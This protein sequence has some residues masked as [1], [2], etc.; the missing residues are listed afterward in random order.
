[1]YQ[2]PLVAKV[3]D[4]TE[5]LRRAERLRNKAGQGLQ[6]EEIAD[7]CHLILTSPESESVL[8]LI[9]RIATAALARLQ[10]PASEHKR[11]L[12]ELG[13]LLTFPQ[14]EQTAGVIS[15]VSDLLGEVYLM[16]KD[17]PSAL[18]C[19]NR[20]VS[21]A[22]VA[23][24]EVPDQASAYLHLAQAYSQMRNHKQAMRYAS[25]AVSY[26]EAQLHKAG[27]SASLHHRLELLYNLLADSEDAAGKPDRARFWRQ[28]LIR[29]QT[30]LRRK[31]SVDGFEHCLKLV[32]TG[33]DFQASTDISSSESTGKDTPTFRRASL[34]VEVQGTG[35]PASFRRASLQTE[36][37]KPVKRRESRACGLPQSLSSLVLCQ[38]YKRLSH[39][40]GWS[41]VTLTSNPDGSWLISLKTDT[42]VIEK[43]VD[44]GHPWQSFGPQPLV[45]ML[46]LDEEDRVVLDFSPEEAENSPKEEEN[47]LFRE[48]KT[49]EM[50][51]F[52]LIYST[53]SALDRVQIEAKVGNTV[54]RKAVLNDI[55]LPTLS[56]LKQYAREVLAPI[57]VL[58]DGK[59]DL[60]TELLSAE[61]EENREEM[62]VSITVTPATEEKGPKEYKR[63]YESARK[64]PDL[65]AA[66]KIQAGIRGFLAR[67]LLKVL[68]NQKNRILYRSFTTI[69]SCIHEITLF[70]TPFGQLFAISRNL[71]TLSTLKCT[72]P[73]PIP[74]TS[75]LLLPY[76]S[77][78][79]SPKQ[80]LI[81]RS[82]VIK[83]SQYQLSVYSHGG[84]VE[85]HAHKVHKTL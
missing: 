30:A 38:S 20:A 31:G 19:F 36:A 64:M 52:E 82:Q 6:P 43:I 2:F 73:R 24:Q 51:S 66:T 84:H 65:E 69:Q 63:R 5:L 9:P 70:E 4:M 22:A 27:P 58:K 3:I 77:Q 25:Q 47:E 81:T 17:L 49:S 28:R 44:K 15:Q 46:N 55:R 50:G 80:L 39:T 10:P 57:V 72:V 21:M 60:N 34:Q 59:I 8:S 83:G 13:E 41:Q 16:E 26:S 1:M 32:H 85:I 35:D 48:L 14:L 7:F 42:K 67:K 11:T 40:Q 45:A 75:D 68:K 37:P 76:L 74:P 54:L 56:A 78:I 53:N 61:K 29:Q 18:V 23:A 33:S 62:Q 71:S 79:L 12:I